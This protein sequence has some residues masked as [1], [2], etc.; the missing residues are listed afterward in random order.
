MGLESFSYITSLNASNPVHATDQVSEGD[1]HLR[2]VKTT[3]LNSFP[4]INAAVN[5]TPTEA[6]LIV[7]ATG[8]TGTGNIAYSASPTF[9]GTVTAA[10]IS[11]SGAITGASFG[12]ITSAN[13]V[14]KSAAESIAGT[15]TFTNLVGG[16]LT[17][18]T[19]GGIAQAN[20]VDK[21]AAETVAGQWNFTT[22]PQVADLEVGHASDTTLSRKAAA[23]LAVEGDA[24]FSHDS[25][26]YTSA[27]IF[28][29]NGTEPTTQ[30]SNGDIFL[31]Y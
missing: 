24:L 25:S 21:S 17:A 20:L 7:G 1:D 12:G 14:D 27:K 22:G 11:A 5:F 30:G 16:T 19:Y 3:L 2:G 4:N 13:L 31:V 9:T 15:W 6:N 10:I 8:K 18:T 26:S 29:S 28:F 23:T